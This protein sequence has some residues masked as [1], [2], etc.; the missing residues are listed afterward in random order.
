MSSN[1]CFVDL[2]QSQSVTILDRVYPVKSVEWSD[3]SHPLE[4]TATYSF[5]GNYEG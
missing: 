5:G 4:G 3:P 1:L 2:E